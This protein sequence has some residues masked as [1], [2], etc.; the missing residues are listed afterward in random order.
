MSRAL[1][2]LRGAP[3]A[4]KTTFIKEH[5]LGEYTLC[6]DDIRLLC[7]SRE[8]KA[9]G[10]FAIT[11]NHENENQ[12]WKILFDL[13]E[14]RMSRGE[15]TVIDA[16]A[17]KTKD[18]NQY[19][20]LADQYRYRIYVIDFTTVPLET[21]LKQNRMRPEYKWVPEAS[22]RNIYA[23]FA[24]QKVPGGIKVIKPE[25]FESVFDAP[26]DL[27]SYKKVVFIGDVHGCYDTLMQYFKDG[28]NPEYSYIF[29][30]DYL[31]RGNQNVE[32]IK[33]L[34]SIMNLPNVC[35][36]EGNHERWIQAYGNEVP[37]ASREFETKTKPQ[38]EA[39]GFTSKEARIFYR[40][41]RQFS[42]F[43]YNG[44]EVLANHG[45]IPNLKQNLLFVP[46]IAF[47][48]GVGEYA[49]YNTIAETWMRD[50]A[51]NQ[52]QVFGHRNT[53]E[54]PTW[55]ADRVF[56][57][58]GRVEH[59]GQ[60]RIV[61]LNQ[62]CTWNIIELD[63]C[64]P[65]TKELNTELHP[66]ETVEEAVI[67]LRNNEF[68]Q[69]KPLGDGIS[70]FNFTRE[71]FF[72]GNWNRQTVLARGLFI[73]TVNNKI[74]A[75]SYEKFFK[76]NEVRATELSSLKN[77]LVFPVT[78]YVKE[79]GFLGIV[80]YNHNTEDLFIATKS[81][82][83]GDFVEYFKACLKPY[84]ENLKACLKNTNQTLVF[85]CEDPVHDPH[86]IEYKEA[87]VVLLD[88]IENELTFKK[89]DYNTLTQIAGTVG[90]Q[91]KKRAFILNTWEDFKKLYLD[92]QDP[93]WQYQEEYIEGFVFEDASGFMTKCKSAYYNLWKK[94]RGVADQT[95]RCG[96]ITR[97]GGLLEAIENHF[98]GFCRKCFA[99]DRNPETKEYPYR[100]N[101]INLRNMF[102]KELYA[103][104]N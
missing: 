14:Y 100:T 46:T 44:I 81:T 60:L 74:V 54:S 1:F 75:R 22:I 70:S 43:T 79:N 26:I 47:I 80:S 91:A 42:H 82:N 99:Q 53:E 33:W 104:H 85:E 90:V 72:K 77:R 45:G 39:G 94:L 28:I 95:L 78:A 68:V 86:I 61:E 65:V 34:Y 103:A 31:D 51:E 40:K 20:E 35:L 97:T 19:K 27:S 38:L 101:I 17:S 98:Y 3:G 56:N 16:T 41:V 73:D 87:R 25:E 52:Y 12:T 30:G 89:A 49:D 64:Q 32:T 21:C 29:C 9:D 96:Y 24:T 5:H 6:P 13:L 102:F 93:E 57:L 66:V 63:D 50:T 92:M 4:G 18:L 55:L 7:S 8:L 69:E 11:R 88:A 76:V 10:S 37:A 62:D 36:L 48:K 84:I 58:E 83:K 71:V 15:L 67:Y 59:G 23:R 2:C